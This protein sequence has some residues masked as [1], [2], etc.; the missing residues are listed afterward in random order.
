MD[1][2]KVLS[3]FLD[4]QYDIQPEEIHGRDCLSV[5]I[6]IHG[7]AV[8]LVHICDEEITRLPPFYLKDAE[9]FGVLAHVLP[10]GENS[11]ADI[12]VN[13][14]D[15]VSVNFQRP[16]LAFE[17]SLKRH[18][19][20]LTKAIGDPVWNRNE[21]LRE[22]KTNWNSIE[23][24]HNTH[25]ICS[26]GSDRLEKMQIYLP[27]KNHVF[28]ISSCSIGIPESN[29][30]L[31]DFL[32][33]K[34]RKQAEGIGYV[35]PLQG[36]EPAPQRGEEL[37]EW[38][39]WA[40]NN[41]PG[42]FQTEFKR[43]YSQFRAKCFYIVFNAPTSSGTTWFGLHFA[44]KKKKLLPLIKERLG[45]WKIKRLSVDVL[46]KEL[47]MP[48]SGANPSLFDKK[49]LLVGCGSV[50]SELAMKLGAA[51]LGDISMLD[52]DLFLLSN[53]YRHV[54]DK[55]F[56]GAPKAKALGITMSEY[57]PWINAK[58]DV[59]QLLRLREYS[60]L[61]NYFDLIIIAIGSPTHERIFHEFLISKKI[62]IPVI[63]TWLEGHGIGGHA[64]LEIPG[65]RGCLGCVY[66][67]KETGRPGLSSNLNFF[68]PDQSIVKNY[69]GCS[70]MFIPYGAI[71]STQ[72][73]LIAA[74]LAIRYLEGKISQSQKV[75]WKGSCEV[76][77]QNGIKLSPRYDFFH[78]SLLPTP[79][80]NPLCDACRG[81]PAVTYT[82]GERL[83]VHIA[84][85][86]MD[87]WLNYRQTESRSV[88][89]AGLLVGHR[90]NENEIWVDGITTPIETDINK[91]NYFKLDD[92][93]HNAELERFFNESFQ[94]RAY[95]GTWHTHPEDSPNP[96]QV[97]L[98]DWVV[99]VKENKDRPLFFVIIGCMVIKI[100]MLAFG[101]VIEL[102][103]LD[104]N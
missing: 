33:Y 34:N 59:E 57:F 70:D 5:D 54:L 24:V 103:E 62:K 55:R 15:S 30:D 68:E 53:L 52:P 60:A 80:Y 44:S 35:I 63:N 25:L 69:A 14:S 90:G 65:T 79:L 51:G 29:S 81:V 46:N 91:P 93:A 21:L 87:R 74:D 45:E 18:T 104:E 8:T 28:G 20:L 7:R 12:C 92:K 13:D 1:Y 100:F 64:T 11:L 37:P 58:G 39:L 19:D 95:L 9:Q 2:E 48:R 77:I 16:E 86:I 56:L 47:L 22:F 67:D 96:S 101:P 72:T 78:Q 6:E 102:R 50:G 85:D 89:S 66:I 88:E 49:I 94:R 42:E 83:K 99:H 3:Y 4:S 38:Y 32:G 36:L 98:D 31:K 43:H 61:F 26:S 10:N 97:D 23:P 76:A 73:A 71:H 84:Q 27:V 41:I 75:S 82:D 17:E 40:I